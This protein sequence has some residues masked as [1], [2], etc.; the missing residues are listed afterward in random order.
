M[1][2]GG[3]TEEDA[4]WN[5]AGARDCDP[6][7]RPAAPTGLLTGYWCQCQRSPKTWTASRAL[8]WPKGSMGFKT[9][10]RKTKINHTSKDGVH[11]F[12]EK[13]KWLI[14][15]LSFGIYRLKA[16]LQDPRLT[17]WL[18]M[19]SYLFVEDGNVGWWFFLLP[20]SLLKAVIHE[21]RVPTDCATGAPQNNNQTNLGE[22][23]Y[24]AKGLEYE[25]RH[26]FGR[27][28]KLM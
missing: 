1:I 27:T 13:T 19:W 7:P 12:G 26:S 23:L 8:W 28:K 2:G 24:P 6:E 25:F 10:K 9:K 16:T 15:L 11:Q 20:F 21:Y 4:L 14:P 3:C 17:D 18:L 5:F 22:H